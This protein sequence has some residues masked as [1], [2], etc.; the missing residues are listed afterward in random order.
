[1]TD[2][3][4]L[5]TAG[6]A[7]PTRC[8][9]EAF[10]STSRCRH[11]LGCP[12]DI[13]V[14]TPS[15]RLNGGLDKLRARRSPSSITNSPYGK[16]AIALLQER[17][18]M[19]GFEL[20]LLPVTTRASS[21]RRPGC[22]SARSRHRLRLLLWGWGVMNSTSLKEA[23]ATGYPREKMFGVWWAAARAAT[24]SRGR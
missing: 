20:L 1:V 18:K 21:R 19:H 4:P 7:A 12:R 10:R 6:Y 9:G 2:K 8:D 15:G 22:R 16:G 5:I 3:I 24:C 14:Q 23:V 11:L 13:L 17:A